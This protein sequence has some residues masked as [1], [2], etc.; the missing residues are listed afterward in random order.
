MKSAYTPSLRASFTISTAD[1]SIEGAYCSESGLAHCK[2]RCLPYRC[3]EE[4]DDIA[5]T[6]SLCDAN[7]TKPNPRWVPSIFFGSFTRFTAPKVAN[8]ECSSPSVA[9]KATLR[10]DSLVAPGTIAVT[11]APLSFFFFAEARLLCMNLDTFLN[12]LFFV[13]YE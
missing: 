9:W 1:T 11:A 6:A 2:M 12:E 13:F 4:S 10:T 5:C 8:R 3:V 7:S